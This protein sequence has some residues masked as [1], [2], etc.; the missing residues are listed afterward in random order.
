MVPKMIKK[1]FKQRSRQEVSVSHI[2]RTN[3]IYGSNQRP[4][5]CFPLL[6]RSSIATPQNLMLVF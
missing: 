2:R 4:K 1:Y 6:K 3:A 5:V